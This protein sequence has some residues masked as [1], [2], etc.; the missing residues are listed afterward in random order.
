MGISFWF[1]QVFYL[2]FLDWRKIGQS[3]GQNLFP[4]RMVVLYDG[5]CRLCRRTIV[6]LLAIDVFDRI[7]YVNA[8]DEKAT[9]N[10]DLTS[11]NQ[12]DL[13]RDMHAIVG[14]RRWLVYDA[15]RVIAKQNPLLWPAVPLLYLWPVTSIGRWI[16]R[17]VA[18]SRTCS[19]AYRRQESSP[20]PTKQPSLKPMLAVG[21]ILVF[22]NVAAGLAHVNSWPLS[23]YPTFEVS[24]WAPQSSAFY[25]S[26]VMPSG[27]TIEVLPYKEQRGF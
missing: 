2:T 15:Y 23:C 24:L 12:E 25:I 18:D 16:Y 1:L 14:N 6:T 20:I 5:N 13:L 17:K 19:L 9:K 8:L 21:S 10:I 22:G 3:I 11:I 7:D 27:K 4:K 26:A